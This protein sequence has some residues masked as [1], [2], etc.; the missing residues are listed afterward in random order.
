MTTQPEPDGQHHQLD[1]EDEQQ[2]S[3]FRLQ[4]GLLR[5]ANE[6]GASQ[7]KQ[8][9]TGRQN[10]PQ[11]PPPEIQ[12]PVTDRQNVPPLQHPVTGRQSVPQIQPPITGR[13][14]VPPLPHL[15][16]ERQST[17]QF[18]R[19]A[20]EKQELAPFQSS[21]TDRQITLPLPP[22]ETE[23]QIAPLVEYPGKKS[24]SAL[25]KSMPFISVAL[26]VVLIAL[27][28][29]FTQLG[30]LPKPSV[31]TSTPAQHVVTSTPTGSALNSITNNTQISPLLFGTNMALF[32]TGD[33]DPILNSEATRQQLKNIGVRLMRM[34][35][36]PTLSD[37]TEIAAAEAIKEIGA[38]PLIVISG[39]EFKAGSILQSDQ[40]LLDL[41]S[42]VFGKELVYYE[43]GNEADLQGIK[44]DAY[45]NA[46]NQVVPTLK[47]AFPT[48]RFIAPDN[49]QFT[50]RYLK[51][52]L[53]GARPHP[54]GVSWHEYTCSVYWSADFCLANIDS[55]TI[56]MTQ[57][58]AVMQEVL[59]TTLPIW[60]SEWNYASDQ[61]TVGGKPINDGKY[62]NRAFM[63]AW[64]TKAMATL[65]ANRVFASMQYF[66][67]D[68][69]MPLVS[70]NQIGIE[71]QI[72][73]QEYKQ[74]MVNGDTPPVATL[75]Y[76]TPSRTVNPREVFSFEG[77]GVYGWNSVGA[78]MTQPINSTAQA[79]DGTH[80]LEITL[81]NASEDDRPFVSVPRS[82][83]PSVPRPGQMITA[84]IY[85]ANPAALVN[86]KI[87]VSDVK[88]NWNFTNDIT[89]TAGQWNKV[90]YS[91]PLNFSDQVAGVGIQFYTA[92]PG[93]SSTVYIDAV[94]WA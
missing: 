71:G 40:H 82:M 19:P 80:S 2:I 41:F 15:V 66:A 58:R 50:R 26:N 17:G 33:N 94:N 45:V 47:Q 92:R 5:R 78:G 35:T 74:I 90:W 28:I 93:I 79:F 11:I 67:T 37:A 22:S 24:V 29:G 64:T 81:S 89:L 88:Q 20:T 31:H 18:L 23:K 27:V 85:V 9:I 3:Q 38:V 87:F 6:L 59:G 4:G 84:Y 34:P 62:N 51:T 56:H 21:E 46:W 63:Q 44:V 7:F 52:F 73:Q 53:Q 16:T 12:P 86:A 55:W 49:Y 30:I 70:N 39:P 72:F 36:R 8:P 91:L 68:Q 77:G 42:R 43:F 76:P 25:E 32:G 48:A 14:H 60:I 75:K 13:Q 57:A 61:A 83:L 54:D 1:Q 65:I 69:P 10:V